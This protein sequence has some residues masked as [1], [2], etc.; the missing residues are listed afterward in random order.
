MIK[1]IIR[2][3]EGLTLVE[4]ILAV[5]LS[6]VVIAVAMSGW[7]FLFSQIRRNTEGGNIGLRMDYALENIRRHLLG[8]TVIK[9]DSEFT[10]TLLTRVGFCFTGEKDIY[11]VTPNKDSD[12]ADY[13]YYIDQGKLI[14]AATAN[15]IT[16]YET[17]IES[18]YN[19]SITFSYAAP[20][21]PNM[22]T[23]AVTATAGRTNIQVI[24]QEDIGLGFAKV[25]K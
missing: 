19:P 9:E 18:R 13:C 4:L 17:L 24:K 10:D 5:V 3:S 22:L 21:E 15:A 2:K 6:S 8:A 11:T 23:V 25:K 14:L 1:R 16:T 12:N 20:N 7:N